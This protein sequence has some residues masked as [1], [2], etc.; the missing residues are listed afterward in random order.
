MYANNEIYTH[1]QYSLLIFFYIIEKD[2]E[3]FDRVFVN[4][5]G[6]LTRPHRS[7]EDLLAFM[8]GSK[9]YE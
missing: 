3:A 9:T 1:K 5:F 7:L 4:K 6:G 8:A 2:K